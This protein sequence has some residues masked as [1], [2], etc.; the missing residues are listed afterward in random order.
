MA[1]P[2]PVNRPHACLSAA[3]IVCSMALLDA[4]LVEQ[5]VGARKVGVGIVVLVGDACFLIALRY[6]A[7]WVGAEVRSAQRGY[8]MVLWFFYVFVLEIKV[9]FV[10]QNYKARA[11]SADALG[12]K[13][14]TLL[15]S[16]SVPVLYVVL[17]AIDHME[18]VRP[19]RKREE[20]RS[21]LFWVVVDLLDVL[22]VQ[23]GLWEPQRR[24][25]PLWA[26]GLTFF[27]CYILLLVL[28]CVSLSEISMQGVNIAPHRMMLYPIL[29]LAAVN[30]ATLL[31]RGG[32]LLLYRE[33]RVSG[34][35]VGKNVV[36][37]VLK[38]C[39]FAQYRKS[40]QGATTSNAATTTTTTMGVSVGGGGVIGVG[41]SPA[42]TAELHKNSI[43]V[44][45]TT[46]GH[47]AMGGGVP[48]SMSVPV[49]LSVPMHVP[50]MMPVASMPGIP[51]QVVIQDLTT[52]PE[53]SEG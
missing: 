19:V 13:A 35:L 16:V 53:E 25:L 46:G 18:Y 15:L 17:A 31:I 27:Y 12:R 26:E 24:G 21:R 41:M 32:N 36:A 34:V 5:S 33:A 30:V 39:S 8:A 7:A 40:L 47:N 4:Y 43:I 38:A 22:D 48:M 49:T 14:L 51:P 29:S 10:Y 45:H 11:S 28:P 42:L 50:V 20:I 3:L 23:A 1:P 9:Y 6:V 37:I 52:L 44:T 2:P